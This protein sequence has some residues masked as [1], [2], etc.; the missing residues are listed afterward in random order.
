MLGKRH[1]DTQI[2]VFSQSL[3]AI[4][5]IFLIFNNTFAADIRAPMRSDMKQQFSNYILDEPSGLTHHLPSHEHTAFNPDNIETGRLYFWIKKAPKNILQS[6]IIFFVLQDRYGLAYMIAE[7]ITLAEF[8]DHYNIDNIND[9]SADREGYEEFYSDLEWMQKK[10]EE[11]GFKEIS[12][13]EVIQLLTARTSSDFLQQKPIFSI[14]FTHMVFDVYDGMIQ[15]WSGYR[16]DTRYSTA[17]FSDKTAEA[18]YLN[19]HLGIQIEDEME[20][21]TKDKV[22]QTLERIAKVHHDNV[23]HK[24]RSSQ[25]NSLLKKYPRLQ[26]LLSLD[27]H[28]QLEIDTELKIIDGDYHIDGDLVFCQDVKHSLLITGDLKVKGRLFFKDGCN[29]QILIVAGNVEA[30]HFIYDYSSYY[31][32]PIFSNDIHISGVT[33]LAAAS[34]Y[35]DIN[36]GGTLKTQTL[37]HNKILLIDPMIVFEQAYHLQY[38]DHALFNSRG[39]LEESRL[40]HAL[41]QK[42]NI[43][44]RP[45]NKRDPDPSALTDAFSL[46]LREWATLFYQFAGFEKLEYSKGKYGAVCYVGDGDEIVMDIRTQSGRYCMEHETLELSPLDKLEPIGDVQPSSV[47]LAYRFYWIMWTFSNWD[48]R[49]DGPLD[50]WKNPQQINQ[51]FENG[52][53]YFREDPHLALYWILHFGLLDD[54]RYGDI[55]EIMKNSNHGLVKG[56]IAFIDTY[57]ETGRFPKVLYDHINID[58]VTHRIKKHISDLKKQD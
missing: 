47:K 36:I 56:A 23:T 37:I 41:G 18:E 3:I 9:Y 42:E 13:Q 19:K 16:D 52:K 49:D 27:M 6:D 10:I 7:D 40:Y 43:F 30:E 21:V 54:P 38:L 17:F 39:Y 1:T 31:H 25:R 15:T 20:V 5:F 46:Y 57:R 29:K 2:G 4:F 35:W 8:N 32:K 55:R 44:K 14:Y 22:R 45:L 33:Y 11:Q 58:L 51:A 28:H 50:Y 53:P 26:T 12:Q 48:H 24:Q 34:R